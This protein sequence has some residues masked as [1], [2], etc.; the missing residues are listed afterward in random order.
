VLG[1]LF[2]FSLF[3]GGIYI[4]F[5]ATGSSAGKFLAPP[6]MLWGVVLIHASAFF[7]AYFSTR[8]V[9]FLFDSIRQWLIK[10]SKKDVESLRNGFLILFPL[11]FTPYFLTNGDVPIGRKL[12]FEN[13]F[14]S[15]LL[16][17][18]VPCLSASGLLGWVGSMFVNEGDKK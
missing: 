5:S 6:G 13:Y 8:R 2:V 11:C 15:L 16:N 4:I 12:V 18:L 14:L 3:F 17:M 10:L 1:L 9:V 7:V